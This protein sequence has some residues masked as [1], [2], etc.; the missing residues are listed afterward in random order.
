MPKIFTKLIAI[1]L[2]H[3]HNRVSTIET[4]HTQEKTKPKP[5]IFQ[6]F[7]KKKKSMQ[8]IDAQKTTQENY[9]RKKKKK[10]HREQSNK[11]N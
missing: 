5:E 7:C 11:I 6:K 1:K 4:N 10:K 9:F 3:N 2:P 8:L